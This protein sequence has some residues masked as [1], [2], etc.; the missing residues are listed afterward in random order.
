VIEIMRSTWAMALAMVAGLLFAV[1]K[2]L[3]VVAFAIVTGPDRVDAFNDLVTASAWLAAVAGAVAVCAIAS[4][5]WSA[6]VHRQWREIWEVVAAALATLV[7]AVGLLVNA[8]TSPGG[9]LGANIVAAV[10]FGGWVVLLTVKAA[11]RSLAERLRTE[12][13]G[14]ASLWLAGAVGT[15][16]IAVGA[17]LP[18]ASVEDKGLALATALLWM[19]GLAVIALA[20]ALARQRRLI[21][22][23]RYTELAA[24]LWTLVAAYAAAAIVAGAVFDPLPSLTGVRAGVSLAT[25][26]EVVAFTILAFAA[27]DRLRDLSLLSSGPP[28]FEGAQ[29]SQCGH[30]LPADAHFCPQC[31]APAYPGP[32]TVIV[33]EPESAPEP[34]SGP[35]TIDEPI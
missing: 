15:M 5:V 7:I 3:Q 21:V 19:L 18:T 30:P 4:A 23:R 27:W 17:G 10:G 33:L 9:S 28:P 6:A 32:T 2:V 24:G 35:P 34:T 13:P 14:E 1:G 12:H 29:P 31:G 8:A 11:Q 26:F 22:S 20:L 25:S 16:L